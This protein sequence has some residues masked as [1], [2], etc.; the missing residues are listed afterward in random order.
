MMII[1]IINININIILLRPQIY[2]EKVRQEGRGHTRGLPFVW[3]YLGLI[4]SLKQRGNTVGTRTAQGHSTYRAR[5]VPLLPNK[6]CDEVRFCRLDKT[7]KADVKRIKLNIVS[8][9]KRL[10]VLVAPG[11]T[12]A[13]RKYGRAPPTAI[14]R[15]LQTFLEDLLKT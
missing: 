10:F 14:E 7:Y 3:A 2:A 8:P 12:E 15:E 11:Q 1:N 6:I 5:R 13:E 9:E 4:K